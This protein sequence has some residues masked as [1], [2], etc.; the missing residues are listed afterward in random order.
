MLYRIVSVTLYVFQCA[1]YTIGL[2]T[3]AVYWTTKSAL[4]LLNITAYPL[5]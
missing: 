4:N 2:Y 5:P 3:C 1:K